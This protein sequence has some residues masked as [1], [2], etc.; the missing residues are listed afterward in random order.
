MNPNAKPFYPFNPEAKAFVP[1]KYGAAFDFRSWV[2]PYYPVDLF[3]LNQ[4][5][6][7]FDNF[8]DF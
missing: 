4:M 3:L 5:N 7:W 6:W 2:T 1:N 8:P